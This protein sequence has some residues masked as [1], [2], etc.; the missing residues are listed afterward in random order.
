MNT[1]FPCNTGECFAKGV[2]RCDAP[3]AS[4]WEGRTRA[5]VL[6]LKGW[7]LCW[8]GV[9]G[10]GI[11][12]RQTGTAHDWEGCTEWRVPPRDALGLTLSLIYFAV[13]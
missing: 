6:V 8:K 11:C 12:R 9:W 13:L 7:V 5:Y 1:H 3:K 4:G 10:I 2:M